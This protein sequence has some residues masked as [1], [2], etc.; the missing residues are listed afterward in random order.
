MDL[1][2]ST[3]SFKCRLFQMYKKKQ[4]LESPASQMCAISNSTHS[5]IRPDPTRQH[6]GLGHVGSG[7]IKFILKDMLGISA[8]SNA[9][10][11][12]LSYSFVK[13][14]I[15]PHD[16]HIQAAGEGLGAIWTDDL[17]LRSVRI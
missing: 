17:R 9:V 12:R 3:I 6:P 10:L 2:V 14:T 8:P 11:C 4:S 15:K 16:H 13:T 7:D 5:E 1:V